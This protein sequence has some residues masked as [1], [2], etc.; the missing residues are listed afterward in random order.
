MEDLEC[1]VCG[2]CRGGGYW[3]WGE[4]RFVCILKNI[5]LCGIVKTWSLGACYNWYAG[6]RVQWINVDNVEKYASI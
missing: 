5:F 2:V 6:C 3:R 4:W 1:N